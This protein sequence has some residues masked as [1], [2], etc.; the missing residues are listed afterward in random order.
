[1]K[2]IVA[3][4]RRGNQKFQD[5]KCMHDAFKYYAKVDSSAH[6][7]HPSPDQTIAHS[8]KDNQHQV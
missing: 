3:E 8:A 4:K 1:M 6:V 7:L 5:G 2:K